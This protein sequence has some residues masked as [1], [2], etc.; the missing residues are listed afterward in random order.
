MIKFK[1]TTL[2][3]P[4]LFD[5]LDNVDGIE[6][7]VVEVSTNKLGT[8]EISIRIA[9]SESD[10]DFINRLKDHFRAKLRVAPNIVF[11]TNENI[12]KIR[13]PEE[14]RKAVRFIDTRKKE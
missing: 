9:Y 13:F 14:S 1:G 2:Y 3:P 10:S 5:I 11:D 12:E 6:N 8:D 7:Y 4:A